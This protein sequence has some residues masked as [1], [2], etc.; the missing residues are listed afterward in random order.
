MKLV[1]HFSKPYAIYTLTVTIGFAL[2]AYQISNEYFKYQTVTRLTI[3]RPKAQQPPDVSFCFRMR[4]FNKSEKGDLFK[5]PKSAFD[6]TPP[7]EN[8]IKSGFYHDSNAFIR[9]EFTGDQHHEIIKVTIYV[10]QYY[11]C[12][13]FKN[14][15]GS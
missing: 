2:Q 12:Y 15:V 4:D 9:H 6:Q 11:V 10:K 7:G 13:E 3:H 5:S 1:D 14:N 8:L